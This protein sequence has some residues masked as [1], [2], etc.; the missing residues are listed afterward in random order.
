VCNVVRS[1]AA[2]LPTP[3]TR[4]VA[5]FKWRG[6]ID[7][8]HDPRGERLTRR[9]A[10]TEQRKREAEEMTMRQLAEMFVRDHISTKKP[11]TAEG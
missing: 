11:R 2:F 6:E 3:S 8:G 5:A 9:Q 7:D 10:A 4:R 1:W